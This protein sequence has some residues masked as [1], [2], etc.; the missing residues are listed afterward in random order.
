MRVYVTEFQ[1]SRALCIA[2]PF[3]LGV[4]TAFGSLLSSGIYSLDLKGSP[5]KKLSEV[6]PLLSMLHGYNPGSKLHTRNKF[7]QALI[8]E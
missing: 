2:E 3:I 5:G 8:K 6:S 4:Q 1:P 7:S